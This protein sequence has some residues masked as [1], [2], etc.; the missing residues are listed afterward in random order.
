MT[1]GATN[2]II[3]GEK[4]NSDSNRRNQNQSTFNNLYN[5]GINIYEQCCM[6][7]VYMINGLNG[8]VDNMY[9]V[10]CSVKDLNYIGIPKNS[11]DAYLVYPGFGFQLHTST[12]Y[13][14]TDSTIYYNTGTVPVVF[15][16]GNDSWSGARKRVYT[17]LNDGVS[18]EQYS[19][20]STESIRIFFR[21]NQN[22]ITVLG[23]S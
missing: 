12:G 1:T 20:N 10:F 4:L 18:G 11:D 15:V 23:L 7:G 16:L 21:G 8:N 5:D 9:P 13:T 3:S 22:E 17:Y 19:D 2:F 6:A 14:G